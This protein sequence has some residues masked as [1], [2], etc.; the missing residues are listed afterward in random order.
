[1][2]H[3][4]TELLHHIILEMTLLPPPTIIKILELLSAVILTGTSI[5]MQFLGKLTGP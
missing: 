5:M 1:M 4:T 2:Y 3:L